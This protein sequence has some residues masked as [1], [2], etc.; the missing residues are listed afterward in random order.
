VVRAALIL[1][2]VPI[3]RLARMARWADL[4]EIAEHQSQLRHGVWIVNSALRQRM[5]AVRR[6]IEQFL[7]ALSD[8]A[9]EEHEDMKT[10]VGGIRPNGVLHS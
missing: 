1:G 3:Q 2:P 4:A 6:E 7:E 5:S 9:H 10:W 8:L